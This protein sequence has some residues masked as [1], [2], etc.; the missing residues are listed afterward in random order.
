MSRTYILSVNTVAID[1]MISW[2][3]YIQFR[4]SIDTDHYTLHCILQTNTVLTTELR[5]Y[6]YAYWLPQFVTWLATDPL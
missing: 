2:W 3:Q 5:I 6:S 1:T 4:L